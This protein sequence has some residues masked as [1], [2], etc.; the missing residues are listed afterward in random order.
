M[1]AATRSAYASS[2]MSKPPRSAR[3][4]ST[5]SMAST[6]SATENSR[7]LSTSTTTSGVPSSWASKPR[8]RTCRNGTASSRSATRPDSGTPSSS[9]TSSSDSTTRRRPPTSPTVCR[10]P[11]RV[12]RRMIAHASCPWSAAMASRAFVVGVMRPESRRSAPTGP[13]PSRK[14]PGFCSD[15]RGNGTQPPE[16]RDGAG[17]CL[18]HEVRDASAHLLDLLQVAHHGLQLGDREARVHLPHLAQDRVV[19]LIDPGVGELHGVHPRLAPVIG[20]GTALDQSLR[21]EPV[22][23]AGGRARGQLGRLRQLPGRH[24]GAVPQ[25]HAVR[26]EV[27]DVEADR[28]RDPLVGQHRGGDHLLHHQRDLLAELLPGGQDR[29]PSATLSESELFRIRNIPYQE[30]SHP[31]LP[32]RQDERDDREA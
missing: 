6:T 25:E 4:T 32:N 28:P 1:I 26:L 14:P 5:A 13:W 19:R 9:G 10:S 20:I 2:S 3:S 7:S 12:E 18:G 17:P 30:L 31:R 27:H 24:R 16:R 21:L 11:A 15:V 23:D 29:S 8:S 22:E